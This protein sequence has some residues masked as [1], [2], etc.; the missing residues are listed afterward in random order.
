M[1]LHFIE[2]TRFGLESRDLRHGSSYFSLFLPKFVKIKAVGGISA[3]H[4]FSAFKSVVITMILQP[5]NDGFKR[6]GNG[7]FPE[8]V[9][10]FWEF[11][12]FN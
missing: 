4:L 9:I 1:A 3:A 8:A 10:R 11:S 12:F 7:V 6:P 2:I 5:L